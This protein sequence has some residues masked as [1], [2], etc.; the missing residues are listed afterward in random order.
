MLQQ[1]NVIIETQNGIALDNI[2]VYCGQREKSV[3]HILIPFN[4][5]CLTSPTLDVCEYIQSNGPSILEIGTVLPHS[6]PVSS[7][8][9]I[10]FIL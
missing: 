10:C 3:V 4:D 6:K 5:L 2:G 9:K 8:G 7:R 1:P